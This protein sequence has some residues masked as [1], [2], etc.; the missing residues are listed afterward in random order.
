V[1]A[2]ALTR[3]WLEPARAG[4]VNQSLARSE[5]LGLMKLFSS[6]L[7]AARTAQ[8]RAAPTPEVLLS[9]KTPSSC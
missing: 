4:A 7:A 1:L 6:D 9:A 2:D 8:L 3:E 5:V